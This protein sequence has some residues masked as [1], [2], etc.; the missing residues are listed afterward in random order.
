MDS[1]KSIKFLTEADEKFLKERETPEEDLKKAKILISEV[2]EELRKGVCASLECSS[3]KPRDL[4]II[5]TSGVKGAH[6]EISARDLL[7]IKV[8]ATMLEFETID[9]FPLISTSF[10]FEKILISK[11]G[12]PKMKLGC[13]KYRLVNVGYAQF[14]TSGEYRKQMNLR[15]P[16]MGDDK[17]KEG[18]EIL[19]HW[20]DEVK[21]LRGKEIRPTYSSGEFIYVR[22]EG[23]IGDRRG[24]TLP[25]EIEKTTLFGKVLTDCVKAT[26]SYG[27]YIVFGVLNIATIIPQFRK[28]TIEEPDAILKTIEEDE[29]FRI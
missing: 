21:H 18:D 4:K 1:T 9:K 12:E 11:E 14:V 27:D 13:R 6:T 19:V 26:F 3:K 24:E 7:G 29:E 28:E 20:V 23:S 17:I 15:L 10:N 8:C 16:I 22:L 5:S 25:E 2:E